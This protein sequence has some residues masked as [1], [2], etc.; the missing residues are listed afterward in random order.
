MLGGDCMAGVSQRMENVPVPQLVIK[1]SVPLM[2]S[3]L[4]SSL[5]NMVD[6]IFVSRLSEKALTATT[7]AFP[8]TLLLFA[9]S[10]GTGVGVNSRLSRFLGEGRVQDARE[11]GWT[12]VILAALSCLPFML[13]TALLPPLFGV[14]TTD[15]EIAL[16]GRQYSFVILL[17]S[18]GQTYASMGARLLQATG[19]ANLSMAT[20]LTGS[21]LNCILDPIMIYGLLGCPAMGVRGA[22]IAT[23][24]AQC[25]SGAASTAMYFIKNP[26]LR[27]GRR[28]LRFRADLAG[29]IYRVA[30]PTMLTMAL[31]SVLM[32]VTNR[33]LQTVSGTAIAFYGIFSRLQNFLVMPVTGLSQG[34]IP[35]VGYFFGAGRRQDLRAAVRFAMRIALGTMAVGIA[36][37]VLAPEL[38]LALFDPSPALLAIGRVAMRVLSLTLIPQAIVLICCNAFTGMGNGLVNMRCSLLRGVLPVPLL[39][40]LLRTVGTTWCWFAFVLADAAAATYALA[41]YRRQEAAG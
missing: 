26:E 19:Q 15:P 13:A 39:L 10:I 16:M 18:L 6:S 37:L 21:V 29:E 36:L 9:V 2:V 25:V 32:M 8:L 4:V 31:S 33:I 40:L 23:V 30:V 7:I 38:L 34:L 14:L 22:A 35:V 5:Y 3:T 28:D 41:S 1:S 27:L 24:T 11:T 12:G 17:F 20:Q